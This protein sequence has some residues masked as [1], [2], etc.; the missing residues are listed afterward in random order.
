M[1]SAKATSR[2]RLLQGQDD[3]DASLGECKIWHSMW[4]LSLKLVLY[5]YLWH[6]K[7]MG[8]KSI[9][10]SFM[11]PYL[12]KHEAE[13]DRTLMELKTR[14]GDSATLYC[15]RATAAPQESNQTA[16]A[17]SSPVNTDDAARYRLKKTGATLA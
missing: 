4:T 5:V 13:I 12:S 10:Q 7:T 14:A 1:S 15:S 3:T 9:Y 16:A 8:T 11:K 2:F 17:R 6:P